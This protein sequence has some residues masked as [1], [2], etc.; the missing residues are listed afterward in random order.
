MQEEI[1]IEPPAFFF[2]AYKSLNSIMKSH[3]SLI[4]PVEY[5]CK[6]KSLKEI[7]LIGQHKIHQD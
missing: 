5:P 4:S 3:G 7:L 1:V 2:S 6:N